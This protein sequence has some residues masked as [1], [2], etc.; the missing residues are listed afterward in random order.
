MT[1]M[2]PTLLILAAGMGSRFGGLKQLEQ[3]GPSGETL[4]DYSVHDA[5]KAGFGRVVF[6]IRRDFEAEF[7]EQI[8]RG[9]ERFVDVDYVYQELDEL[10]EG[11]T[12][13]A[14]R[15]KPW[16]T[17]HAIWCARHAITSPFAAI[18]ADDF[19]GGP[20]FGALSDFFASAEDETH[21][22]MVGYRLD[23]TL[24]ENGTVSRGV[25]VSDDKGNLLKVT[26]HTGLQKT[27]A[28][29]AE[30]DQLFRGDE[31]VSMNFWGFQPAVFPLLESRLVEFLK[32]QGGQEK[33]EFY[34]PFAVADMIAKKV[35]SVSVLSTDSEWFGVT[36]RE[37]KPVV[38]ASIARLV[39]AGVYPASL[40]AAQN[41]EVLA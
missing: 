36:Y 24:S 32:S 41:T 10:P 1:L 22:A 17:G 37:D 28:G 39:K 34:I 25:C 15:S 4:L 5:L 29:I 26:E 13:P 31:I 20:A 7:R 8:G 27:E 30:G 33:S 19:Y 2:N 23:R 9:Y 35:A 38:T 21:F 40:W 12:A 16:G 14:A 3:V 18:N 6:V 11:F